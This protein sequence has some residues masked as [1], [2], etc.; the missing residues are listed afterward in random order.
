MASPRVLVIDD[1][2]QSITLVSDI[3]TVNG[4]SVV[5]FQDGYDAIKGL[6]LIKE[7]DLPHLIVLD[8]HMPGFDGFHVFEHIR[9]KDLYNNVPVMAMTALA[10]KDE[11]EKILSAGFDYYVSK[12]IDVPSFLQLVASSVQNQEVMN[13]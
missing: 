13:G 4:Y 10:M 8:I 6:D 7:N 11:Q 2:V 3:L 1:N 9:S 12:P 5:T